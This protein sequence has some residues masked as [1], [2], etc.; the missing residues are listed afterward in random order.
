[1]TNI[2][3]TKLGDVIKIVYNDSETEF[4]KY[5]KNKATGN[6]VGI[7]NN[8]VETNMLCDQENEMNYTHSD[9]TS[10]DGVTMINTNEILFTELEKLL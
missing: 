8:G 5:S 3:I 7:N 2:E 4:S 10:I 9:F 1:M 6:Y